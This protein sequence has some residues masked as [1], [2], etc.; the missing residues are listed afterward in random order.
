MIQMTKINIKK[1]ANQLSAQFDDKKFTVD[2]KTMEFEK[3]GTILHFNPENQIYTYESE[4]GKLN[5]NL[6]A[7]LLNFDANC[8]I[9][10]FNFQNHCTQEIHTDLLNENDILLTKIY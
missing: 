3:N 9:E 4:W 1:N 5:G 8:E 10:L 6:H 7:D 2:G